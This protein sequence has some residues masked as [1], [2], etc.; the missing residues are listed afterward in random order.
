MYAGLVGFMSTSAFS[1][2][3]LILDSVPYL[4]QEK[5]SF[6]FSLVATQKLVFI[7]RPLSEEC[8]KRAFIQRELV[9]IKLPEE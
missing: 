1:R 8:L 9:G 4:A 3:L 5:E 6:I 2:V 7:Q